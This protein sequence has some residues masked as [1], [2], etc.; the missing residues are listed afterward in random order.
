MSTRQGDIAKRRSD[1]CLDCHIT[2]ISGHPS[3]ISRPTP[4]PG[5]TSARRLR[6]S[7]G[8]DVPPEAMDRPSERRSATCSSGAPRLPGRIGCLR[9]NGRM[10]LACL[11]IWAFCLSGCLGL[12]TA[13]GQIPPGMR[14][15]GV[16]TGSKPDDLPDQLLDT[17][18]R[19]DYSPG[20]PHSL[21]HSLD[22]DPYTRTHSDTD[23]HSRHLNILLPLFL[24]PS[25]KQSEV[26]LEAERAKR[27]SNNIHSLKVQTLSES[28][29]RRN[30]E[31][32]LQQV[33]TGW[34][35]SALTELSEHGRSLGLVLHAARP[36]Q[37]QPCSKGSQDPKE[38]AHTKT[39][40]LH[41]RGEN[42]QS[43]NFDHVKD[44]VDQINVDRTIPTKLHLLTNISR[45]ISNSK[46]KRGRNHHKIFAPG[47]SPPR[48]ASNKLT[49]KLSSQTERVSSNSKGFKQD[50]DTRLGDG[51]L[52]EEVLP[53]LIQETVQK[54]QSR[55]EYLES[56]AHDLSDQYGDA[57][58]RRTSTV[59]AKAE[60]TVLPA[61]I[62]SNNLTNHT[63][64]PTD[65]LASSPG[66]FLQHKSLVTNNHASSKDNHASTK[67][68]SHRTQDQT[69][70]EDDRLEREVMSAVVKALSRGKVPEDMYFW[71][72]VSRLLDSNAYL[73]R[74]RRSSYRSRYL[75]MRRPYVRVPPSY[76]ATLQELYKISF[77]HVRPCY[78]RDRYYCMN[79]G[80]CVFV[81]ALDIKTCRCPIG[82]T[83]VR[84]EFIDQEY[85]LSL[86]SNS[87]VDIRR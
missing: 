85:I 82:Y 35:R 33:Q 32:S 6:S 78:R 30:T 40:E 67:D 83:G 22:I 16:T 29:V 42:V 41:N 52:S 45:T 62:D 58:E 53:F 48:S 44:L 34:L 17:E 13:P 69:T 11:P 21:A 76:M 38:K 7:S 71:R 54:M 74:T 9:P 75:R 55:L 27:F 2:E 19:P 84:C 18:P 87:L 70:A 8:Q 63:Q 14:R 64:P 68:N 66:D 23:S 61:H 36:F 37:T 4:R 59:D 46:R 10:I 51:S 39:P 65:H 77:N 31:P 5:T 15:P 43:V 80:N 50:L 72:N 25:S 26:T 47:K 57:G 86:L 1:T 73:S 12:H 60:D 56:L 3:S 81:I 24:I 49:A 79:G 20:S 28:A